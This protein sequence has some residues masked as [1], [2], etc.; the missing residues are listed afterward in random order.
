M[1]PFHYLTA[2]GKNKWGPGDI[3][4]IAENEFFESTPLLEAFCWTRS[5]FIFQFGSILLLGN[6]SFLSG[7]RQWHKTKTKKKKKIGKK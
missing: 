4:I 5:S 7:K 2:I 6:L 1:K 3:V